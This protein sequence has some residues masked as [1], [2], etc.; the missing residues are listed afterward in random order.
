MT[1]VD[2]RV[3]CVRPTLSNITFQR[4]DDSDAI[5]TGTLDIAG[6]HPDLS[7][8][9]NRPDGGEAFNTFNCSAPQQDVT[10]HGTSWNASLCIL[11]QSYGRLLHNISP[12]DED[13]EAESPTGRASASLL[14]NATRVDGLYGEVAERDSVFAFEQQEPS[15]ASWAKIGNANMSFDLSICFMNP[16]PRDYEISAKSAADVTADLTSRVVPGTIPG[17]FIYDTS[18]VQQMMGADGLGLSPEQ[19]Q[20]LTIEPP[21]NWNASR[22]LN[23]HDTKERSYILEILNKDESEG[24]T[25]QFSPWAIPVQA[26]H[27]SHAALVLQVLSKSLNPALA[28]QALYTVLLES[29][30]YDLLPVYNTKRPASYG[31]AQ[32]V[33]IPVRWNCFVAVMAILGVHFLL[34]L[35]AVILFIAKSEMSLLGNAWQA[36]SQVMSEDTAYAVRHGA[37]ATDDEVTDT[38]KNSGVA[39]GRIRIA[40]CEQSGRTEARTVLHRR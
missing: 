18:A 17:T 20:L 12:E 4:V 33:L 5:I 7:V 32:E 15:H 24:N 39:N 8:E 28:I 22:M 37:M 1:V 38:F 2:T 6:I 30:Y 9:S 26:M 27:R 36:I 3:L 29:S 16:L 25:W 14:I 11:G 40:K 35:L 13:D 21:N 23:V 31:L 19:R 10:F 34:I